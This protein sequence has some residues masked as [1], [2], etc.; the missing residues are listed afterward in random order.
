VLA[1]GWLSRQP[2]DFAQAI[3]RES[4]PRRAVA[5]QWI[6]SV[7][8]EP[9]GIFAVLEGAMAVSIAGERFGPHVVDLR[10]PGDWGGACSVLFRAPRRHGME[11]MTD[12][13]LLIVPPDLVRRM[14]RDDACNL[15][16]FAALSA[17]ALARAQRAMADLLIPSPTSRLA[18]TLLRAAADRPVLLPLTQERLATMA[19]VSRQLANRAMQDFRGAGW[20]TLGYGTVR[21]LDTAALAACAQAGPGP[22]DPHRIVP[23]GTVPAPHL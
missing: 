17:G 4:Q 1:D 20:I 11:A 9:G 19:N 14:I 16:R 23:A 6:H 10:L 5:G 21:L 7:G 22:G 13:T 2:A 8:D 12:T 18:A 3:L 15:R